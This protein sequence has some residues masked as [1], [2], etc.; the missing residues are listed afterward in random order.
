MVRYPGAEKLKRQ[1]SGEVYL[2]TRVAKQ[3]RLE[4]LNLGPEDQG[5]KDPES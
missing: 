2:S 1:G 5:P 4:I 3:G